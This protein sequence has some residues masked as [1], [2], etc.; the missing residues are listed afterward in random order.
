MPYDDMPRVGYAD[1]LRE[2]AARVDVGTI[3][4]LEPLLL[5]LSLLVE[6]AEK[7]S[8]RRSDEVAIRYADRNEIVNAIAAGF[9]V[10]QGTGK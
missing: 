7:C 4:R 9:V 5:Q 3:T 10:P 8:Q 2:V 6:R 1:A